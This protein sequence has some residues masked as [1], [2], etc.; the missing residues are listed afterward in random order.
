MVPELRVPAPFFCKIIHQNIT[1]GGSEPIQRLIL[2]LLLVP[3]QRNKAALCGGTGASLGAVMGADSSGGQLWSRPP[4][5]ASPGS[6]HCLRKVKHQPLLFL[7]LSF[8][9]NNIISIVSQSGE[10]MQICVEEPSQQRKDAMR[11][12]N[13]RSATDRNTKCHGDVE[14]VIP[15]QEVARARGATLQGR[16]A[17]RDAGTKRTAGRLGDNG[18]GGLMSLPR[19]PRQGAL[20]FHGKEK[21]LLSR[22]KCCQGLVTKRQPERGAVGRGCW[23]PVE[24]QPQRP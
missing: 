2:P 10:I 18:R 1:A 12:R 23:H 17:G 22:H 11:M 4:S 15:A 6:P 13:P 20:A 9:I 8:F 24:L 7:S 3:I 14:V 21:V 5:N 16:D 19:A